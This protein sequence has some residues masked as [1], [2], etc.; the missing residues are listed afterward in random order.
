MPRYQGM[1]FD[2]DGVLSRTDRLHYLAW[3]RFTE[4]HGLPFSEEINRRMLG[5]SREECMDIVLGK[6]AG[7]MSAEEKLSLIREKNELFLAY[8]R[9]LT[10]KDCAPGVLRTLKALRARGVRLALGSS[11]QNA[12]V[13]IKKLG[14]PA[15]LDVLVDGT[16]IEHKKP[17]PDIFRTAAERLGLPAGQCL[18]VD[19]AEAGVEAALRGGFDIAGIGPA[20]EDERC[21]YQLEVFSDLMDIVLPEETDGDH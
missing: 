5:R 9:N 15:Y 6:A 12:P 7:R 4:Q 13:V 1:I 19:D 11:S 10:E 20:A 14:L 8:A 18:V 3:V 2:M 17:A 16:E 21:T